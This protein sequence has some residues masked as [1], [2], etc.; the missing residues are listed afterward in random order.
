MRLLFPRIQRVCRAQL[1]SI[2]G[3]SGWGKRLVEARAAA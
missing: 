2:N 1:D 3:A